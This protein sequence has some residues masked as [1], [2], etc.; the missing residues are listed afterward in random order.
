MSNFGSWIDRH[1][2]HMTLEEKIE[3]GR[4]L[5][6]PHPKDPHPELARRRTQKEIEDN[7]KTK[8]MPD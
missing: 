7:L 1:V 8:E 5:G 6:V 3:L 2:G 4:N